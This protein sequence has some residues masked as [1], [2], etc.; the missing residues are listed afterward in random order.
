MRCALVI[1]IFFGLVARAF[2]ENQWVLWDQDVVLV[3]GQEPAVAW[4]DWGSFKTKAACE[5]ERRK[6]LGRYE[7]MSKF[8]PNDWSK[9]GDTIIE[10]D[11]GKVVRQ[12]TY[13]CYPNTMNPRWEYLASRGNWYLMGPPR[14]KYDKTAAYLRGFQVLSDRALTEWNLMDAFESRQVCE[15]MRDSLHSIEESTYNK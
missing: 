11:K 15:I 9:Q 14:T 6:E 12:T 13:Y 3:E 4:F 8:F 7:Q 10:K 1:L 5:E 2:A